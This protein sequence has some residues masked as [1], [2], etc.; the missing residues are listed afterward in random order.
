M[1][2]LTKILQNHF[3]F[4]FFPS[5]SGVVESLGATALSDGGGIS[6][7]GSSPLGAVAGCSP[8]FEILSLEGLR[9]V[10]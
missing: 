10:T 1:N 9:L 7:F 6:D 5:S 2:F 3:T 4:F 8:S